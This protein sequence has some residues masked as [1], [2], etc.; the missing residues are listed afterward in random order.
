[1]TE[2]LK[3]KLVYC[4]TILLVLLI[5]L[6]YATSCGHVY[7]EEIIKTGD[8][9]EKENPTLVLGHYESYKKTCDKCKKVEFGVRKWQ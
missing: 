6:E 3:I 5:T 2:E 9:F 7:S 1:M 4:G 8:T